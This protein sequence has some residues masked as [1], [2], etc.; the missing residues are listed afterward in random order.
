[1]ASAATTNRQLNFRDGLWLGLA[2]VAHALLLLIPVTR[3][4][5]SEPGTDQILV[6][7]VAQKAVENPFVEAPEV[8]KTVIPIRQ[9]APEPKPIEEQPAVTQQEP[10][11]EA[12][13]ASPDVI[14]ST[15][16]LRDSASRFDWPGLEA[17]EILQLG[18]F[19][20]RPAPENWRP[21][22][23]VEENMF[24]G[25][26]LP[27][28]TEI[29]DRWLAAD[30]SHNVV[31]NTPGGDTFCGRAEAWDPMQPLVEHVMQFRPCGG[32]GKRSFEMPRRVSRPLN[33]IGVANSTTN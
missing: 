18:I 28:K 2:V 20:P 13:P 6:T 12:V 17:D 8:E 1:M 9:D 32:G 21:G 23:G 26:V 25:M 10:P 27:K 33:V 29:V 4:S 5:A 30:G 24:N 14:L 31:I 15:A 7:L 22:I 11:I 19:T 3:Y 16:L